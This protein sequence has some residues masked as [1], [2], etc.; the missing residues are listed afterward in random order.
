M[1]EFNPDHIPTG[2]G[3]LSANSRPLQVFDDLLSDFTNSFHHVFS[4]SGASE[5]HE[6]RSSKC[7]KTPGRLRSVCK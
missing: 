6:I 7:A 1:T 4:V 2:T 5:L 3:S